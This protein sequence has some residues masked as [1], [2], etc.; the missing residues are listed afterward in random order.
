MG[1]LFRIVL[2]APGDSV[3]QQAAQAAFKRV[4]ELN[5]ILSDYLENSEL[6]KLSATAGTGQAIPV[7]ID[8]WKVLEKS[9]EAAFQSN[10]AFDVTV[11]PYVSLWRR[12]RRQQEIPASGALAIARQ[13]V[14]YQ[15]IRL[16]P[17]KHTVQ[18]MVPG[19]KLDLGG[20]G[21]GYAADEALVVLRKYG[22]TTAL[23]DAGGNMVAGDAPPGKKG[24]EI[25]IISPAA[26]NADTVTKKILLSHAAVSTSGDMYQYVEIDG[27]KYSHIVDPHTGL[28]LTTQLMVTV[29]APNGTTADYLSTALSVLEPVEGLRLIGK[30]KK[31]AALILINTEGKILKWESEKWQDLS[32][33][34]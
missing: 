8:L 14:G 24:W 30:T 34:Q 13:K 15:H 1:T 10:G 4:D 25:G 11:G 6:N 29:L 33:S 28:G 20:I 17:H 3:A 12:A 23:V 2:Y 21:K 19:M 32:K 31:A 7:S 9:R 22:I 18:L 5:K 27:K 26:S 16:D